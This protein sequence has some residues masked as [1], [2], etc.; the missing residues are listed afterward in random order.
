MLIVKLPVRSPPSDRA[1]AHPTRAQLIP[2]DDAP[3]LARDVCGPNCGKNG[4]L[5]EPIGFASDIAAASRARLLRNKAPTATN[6]LQEAAS[7]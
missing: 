3:L 5:S 6:R 4:S 2:A 7:R 1:F